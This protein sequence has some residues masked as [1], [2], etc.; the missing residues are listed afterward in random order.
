MQPIL[1][2]GITLA[3]VGTL[4]YSLWQWRDVQNHTQELRCVEAREA[5]K[6]VEVR[7][8][9]LAAGMS[10]DAYAKAEEEDVAK[11]VGALDAA[12]SDVEIDSVMESH[13]T[14]IGAQDAAIDA[15][16]DGR[17]NQAFLEQ[18]LRKQRI[19]GEVKQELERAAKAVKLTCS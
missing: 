9:A 13:A 17:G 16:V 6:G 19:P 12:K 1:I 15:E 10:V 11:L 3:M 5:L 8:R 4:T 14:A 18:T 2:S 7:A